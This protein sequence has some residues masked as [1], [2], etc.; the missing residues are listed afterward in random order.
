MNLRKACFIILAAAVSGSCSTKRD[1]RTDPPVHAHDHVRTEERTMYAGA[2][3]FYVVSPLLVSGRNNEFTIHITD[4]EDHSPVN[5]GTVTVTLKNKA[6]EIQAGTEGP[7]RE[8]IFLV[9][10]NPRQSGFASL[11]FSLESR[12]LNGTVTAEGIRVY[13]SHDEAHIPDRDAGNEIIFLKEKAWKSD[14]MVMPAMPGPFF[15]IIKT[16][17]EIL[18][19]PGAKHHVHARSAGM[20]RFARENLV[21]GDDVQ[22][23]EHLVSLKGE[24]L[25]HENI[26]FHHA[27][28]RT[29][30]EKSRADY[31][32]KFALLEENAVSEKEFIES[33]TTYLIDSFYYYNVARS[34]EDG[35]LT[36]RSP[37]R[38][39]IHKL[40]VSEGEYIQAGQL[41]AT[42]SSDEKLL[43]KADVPQQYFYRIRRVVSANFRTS[44]SPDVLDIADMDGKLLAVGASVAENQHYL[45]VYFEAV[46]NGELLEGAF[47]E[48][49]LK[50]S[51]C[52]SVISVPKTALVEE[53]GLYSVFVQTGGETYV[54]RDVR[55]GDNDGWNYR[56]V[57]GLL[58][59][60]RVVTKGAMLLKAASISTVMP[61]HNHEH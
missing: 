7:V 28:A 61:G 38:G 55:I 17:G 47:A 11:S 49:Y 33:R 45:P 44:Y 20:V 18:A 40:A 24:G 48:F 58:P 26:T 9:S 56:V 1:T 2:L 39:Y 6:G 10:L 29:R 4:L 59:G 16:G 36:I 37:I 21:A 23:G 43:L 8:G 30:F 31:Q 41:I 27:E 25:A 53:Q 19:I 54:K 15:D 42:I 51:I 35:G 50:T 60:E 57:E 52:D 5:A 13:S 46:N 22:T 14:F 34:Y 32:R 12:D 3:E